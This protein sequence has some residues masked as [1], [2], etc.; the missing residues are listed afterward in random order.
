MSCHQSSPGLVGKGCYIWL[1]DEEQ[2]RSATSL[3]GVEFFWI[4]HVDEQLAAPRKHG[5]RRHRGIHCVQ[6]LRVPALL[7]H[8]LWLQTCHPRAVSHPALDIAFQQQQLVGETTGT[9]IGEVLIYVFTNDI[10]ATLA[11]AEALGAKTLTPK[12][13]VPHGWFAVF[14]DPSGNRCRPGDSSALSRP[15]AQTRLGRRDQLQTRRPD[16]SSSFAFSREWS[17]CQDAS[18]LCFPL[19]NCF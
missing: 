19:R 16:P 2:A 9:R 3:N 7:K 12:T 1:A 5:W 15:G 4:R 18:A 10:D 8:L 6:I 13:E 17:L 14:A 11:H